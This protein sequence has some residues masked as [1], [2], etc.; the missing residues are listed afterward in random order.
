[1]NVYAKRREKVLSKM[2]VGSLMLLYSG[3]AVPGSLDA[4]L[5][6][7]ANHP[8][9]YLTGLR[10][11]NMALLMLKRESSEKMLLFIEEPKPREE[12]WT[13][14]RV[15]PEEAKAVSGIDDVLYLDELE[16]KLSRFLSRNTW[17][18]AYFDCYRNAVGD[19]ES[20]NLAKARQFSAAYPAIRIMDAHALLT[21]MRMVKDDE[22]VRAIEKAIELTDKGLVRVMHEL[23]PGMKE[24]QA[25]AEFEYQIR[26]L[27]AEG[28]AFPTIAGSGAN[29]CMLH[30]EENC[31]EMKAGQLLL[32]DLGARYNGYCADVTRTFPVSGRYSDRQKEIFEAVLAANLAVQDA[33][34]PG[35]SLKDLNDVCKTVLAEKLQK[36]GKIADPSEVGR[37]YM[38]SVSHHLGIDTHDAALEE[39]L[40]APG[41]VITDEPGL[42]ID[43]EEIG[44]RIEDDLLI[45]E[46]GCICLTQK[47]PKTTE[48]IE[49]CM[50]E[51]EGNL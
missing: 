47:I 27:G 50:N 40:L 15:R 4:S 36:M 49:A 2:Q 48:A 29:G 42:Y 19:L 32:M 51:K 24:Y 25:Q 44:I 23:R 12:R 11:E 28:T 3:E 5:P 41:M 35:L 38:H 26:M 31:S 46:H 20:Y 39:I 45:T 43:E 17:E 7:D 33:A 16:S 18:A 8:F 10:R 13:G 9:F 1:M 34:K 30:Y 14:R 37:Y 22:E 21:P 6:F